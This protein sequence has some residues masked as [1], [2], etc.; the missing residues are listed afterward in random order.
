MTER[1]VKLLPSTIR[2]IDHEAFALGTQGVSVENALKEIEATVGEEKALTERESIDKTKNLEAVTEYLELRLPDVQ[3]CWQDVQERI[4]EECPAI[5][6]PAFLTMVGLFAVL[7]EG[8]ML[9]PSLD[10]FGIADH[11]EQL[12]FSFALGAASTIFFH[13][14]LETIHHEEMHVGRKWLIRSLGFGAAVGLTYFGIV[15]GRQ[16]AFAAAVAENPLARFLGE[17]Q[18]LTTVVF[19]FVTLAF[20]IAAA[21]ALS[22]GVESARHWWQFRSARKAIHR[23][24]KKLAEARKSLEAEQEK[25]TH[26]LQALD[27]KSRRCRN[28]CLVHHE[29]GQK[30]GAKQM[31]LWMVW[32]KATT[33]AAVVLCLT[34]WIVPVGFMVT[35][36][37]FLIAWI[38]FYYQRTHPS[39]REIFQHPDVIFSSED[40]TSIGRTPLRALPRKYDLK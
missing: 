20:P 15:R 28:D 21:I 18:T 30:M 12:V 13:F 6:L 31:A 22:H 5:V 10:T 14:T 11:I 25:R 35:G 26:V 7:A 34:W 4:G 9:A 17:Y 27:E 16:A 36:T 32:L 8:V 19:V 38:G 3:R 1:L 40:E 24:P 39:P 2:R 33:V 23:F 37:I 29:R